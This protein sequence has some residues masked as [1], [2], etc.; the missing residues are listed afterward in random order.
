MKKVI[1]AIIMFLSIITFAKA[2]E[3]RFEESEDIVNNGL[4]MAC[5]QDNSKAY[6]FS[7]QSFSDTNGT[8]YEIDL[9]KST[10]KV[11]KTLNNNNLYTAIEKVGDKYLAAGI[12]IS[13]NTEIISIMD[14]NFN[15]LRTEVIGNR[16]AVSSYVIVNIEGD[17]Y[18]LNLAFNLYGNIAA[19]KVSS[20]LETVEEIPMDS[21]NEEK[22]AIIKAYDELTRHLNPGNN[23]DRII[24]DIKDFNGGFIVEHVQV[25][26]IYSSIIF[27]KDDEIKWEKEEGGSFGELI[28]KNNS[29]FT[30]SEHLEDDETFVYE[31]SPKGEVLFKYPITN[32]NE[33]KRLFLGDFN[34]AEYNNC[35]YFFTYYPEV[36]EDFFT[37]HQ[38]RITKLSISNSIINKNEE[39]ISVIKEAFADDEV[40]ITINKEYE[41]KIDKIIVKDS[42]GHEINVKDN[43]F[44]MPASN[45]T[46]EAIYKEEKEES[47]NSSNPETSDL[48]ITVSFI[49]I[50]AFSSLIIIYF[51]RHNIL[52]K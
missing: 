46:I 38:W 1:Y 29:I 13:N 12:N 24:H 43:K 32:I 39:S 7:Y 4:Y 50:I 44:T 52:E 51:T 28:V 23:I 16:I 34:L 8:I 45:V 40:T 6:C 14:K 15:I 25:N 37:W 3:L 19:V 21:I 48:I 47:N 30:L 35:I 49:T 5:S 22:Y 26:G 31:I 36:K 17:Y 18:L 41:N 27:Y 2:S 20:D 10:S 33:Q 9:T 42:N 11:F